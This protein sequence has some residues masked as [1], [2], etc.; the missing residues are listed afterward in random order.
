MLVFFCDTVTII[1]TKTTFLC[2]KI[3]RWFSPMNIT[4][5]ALNLSRT[6]FFF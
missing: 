4:I 6:F 3:M 1:L 5:F 2:Y